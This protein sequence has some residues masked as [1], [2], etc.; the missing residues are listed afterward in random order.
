VL[1]R[2]PGNLGEEAATFILRCLIS[3]HLGIRNIVEALKCKR[4]SASYQRSRIIV[5]SSAMSDI[6]YLV[7]WKYR[8]P[9]V[10]E[11]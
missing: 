10:A 2:W 5:R 9:S 11:I 7:L 4:F 1:W 3:C 6:A 8:G